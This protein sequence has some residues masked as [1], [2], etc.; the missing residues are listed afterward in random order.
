LER[1]AFADPSVRA[2][3][4]PL[5][6]HGA[7]AEAPLAAGESA[8]WLLE[9]N[10]DALRIR[11]ALAELAEETLDIQY[12]IWQDD[13][14]G[15]LLMKHV[16]EAADRGV[17]VRFLID[18]LAV[19]GRHAEL[20]S[21]DAHPRIEVRVFNPWHMRSPALRPFEFVARMSRLNHRMHNKVLVADGR[22][23]ILGGRNIGDRY[24]GVYESFVQN[25]VDLMLAG[26]LLE[27]VMASFET[28]WVSERSRPVGGG[29][30]D[31][32]AMARALCDEAVA[33]NAE[34]LAAFATPP[35]G[36]DGYFADVVLTA[37]R[38]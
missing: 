19:V 12:F 28:Y 14:T 35:G 25:D 18:D 3:T 21:L 30:H 31:G 27:D 34:M 11:I 23:A 22:F 4:G 38:G 16:L 2:T 6:A 32:A 24:F 29:Q 26:A 7:A 13:M 9:D 5:A 10:A 33:A 15:R 37:T 20:E 36:W 8:F 17:R 1:P